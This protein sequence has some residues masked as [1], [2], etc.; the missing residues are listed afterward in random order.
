MKK[1]LPSISLSTSL[2]VLLAFS[3]FTATGTSA[4]ASG[5]EKSPSEHTDH[6]DKDVKHSDKPVEH[7][8]ERGH[9]EMEVHKH[10]RSLWTQ[11]NTANKHLNT[12]VD[13]EELGEVHEAAE[14]LVGKLKKLPEVSK[15][16]SPDKKK[17]IRGNVNS[18]VKLLDDI[19]EAADKGNGAVV[20]KKMKSLDGLFKVLKSQ[21]PSDITSGEMKMHHKK[22][23]HED[24]SNEH[25]HQGHS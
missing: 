16:L 25:Q 7:H 14:T 6:H 20:N 15:D 21:Y 19:H 10:L 17:R 12:L 23:N 4:L 13:S 3:Y 8:E 22:M 5:Q 11:I 24:V 9:A 1:T 18:M 2:T